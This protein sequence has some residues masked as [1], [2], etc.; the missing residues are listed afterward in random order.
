MPFL[1]SV[2]LSFQG[3]TH[4]LGVG[5]FSKK[6]KK[7]KDTYVTANSTKIKNGGTITVDIAGKTKEEVLKEAI[8]IIDN[9]EPLMDY[10]YELDDEH[11]YLSWVQSRNL[12]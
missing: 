6:P 7:A 1:L 11:N 8:S 4:L 5:S 12:F 9:F 10:Q 2:L 3:S